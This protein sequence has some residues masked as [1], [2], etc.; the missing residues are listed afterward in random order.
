MLFVG[1]V[2]QSVQRLASGW[3]VRDR[4]KNPCEG[5]IFSTPPDRPWGPPSLLYNGYRIF[6]GGKAEGVWC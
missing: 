4:K 1:L 2:A 6:P 5:E 3:T